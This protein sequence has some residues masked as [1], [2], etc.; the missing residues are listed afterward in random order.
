MSE[1][2]HLVGFSEHRQH[3]DLSNLIRCHTLGRGAIFGRRIKIV[4]FEA[5]QPVSFHLRSE[6]RPSIADYKD[7][8]SLFLLARLYCVLVDVSTIFD[9]SVFCWSSWSKGTG[10]HRWRVTRCVLFPFIHDNGIL[11]RGW[12][13]QKKKN[14]IWDPKKSWER[15]STFNFDFS[16]SVERGVMMK[17]PWWSRLISKSIVIIRE[18]LPQDHKVLFWH[19]IPMV[20]QFI[21]NIT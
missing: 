1:W 14:L 10:L 20:K 2:R 3:H 17:I 13:A 6:R 21:I 4:L 11:S 15:Y 18:S 16:V 5:G 19:N 9:H 7:V 8:S 12:P